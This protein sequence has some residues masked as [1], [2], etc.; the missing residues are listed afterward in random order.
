DIGID[1]IVPEA[2][3]DD[4]AIWHIIIAVDKNVIPETEDEVSI[5]Y[6]GKVMNREYFDF[7][8][9]WTTYGISSYDSRT[10]LL[11]KTDDAT[12]PEEYI[13]CCYLPEE[14]MMNIR[15]IIEELDIESYPDEY[16][17]HQDLASN[18]YMTLELTVCTESCTKTVSVPETALSY[19][20]D[21]PKGQEFLNAFGAIVDIITHTDEWI[22]LPDYE[23]YYD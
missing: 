4:M 1:P 3:T 10:G 16:N 21:D 17:P 6:K 5:F 14:Q 15:N 8:I 18:P 23:F 9:R 22:K 7:F 12:R 20:T 19:E 2:G 13:T 11:I